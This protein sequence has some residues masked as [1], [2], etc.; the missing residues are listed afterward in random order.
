[1]PSVVPKPP[2]EQ[3]GAF[4]SINAPAPCALLSGQNAPRTWLWSILVITRYCFILC[5]EWISPNSFLCIYDKNCHQTNGDNR[6]LV[7]DVP[8]SLG[9]DI[10]DMPIACARTHPDANKRTRHIPMYRPVHSAHANKC[11]LICSCG[12]GELDLLWWRLHELAGARLCFQMLWRRV[13]EVCM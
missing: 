6:H 7:P 10:R 1:M 9:R 8:I 13:G 12:V 4:F 11:S 2:P 5:K 3:G